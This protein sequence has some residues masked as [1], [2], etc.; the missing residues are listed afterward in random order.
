MF[1]APTSISCDIMH[2]VQT[3]KEIIYIP[4]PFKYSQFPNIFHCPIDSLKIR[5][6]CKYC[7][8]KSIEHGH[9]VLVPKDWNNDNHILIFGSIEPIQ[10]TETHF[11]THSHQN[12]HFYILTKTIWSIFFSYFVYMFNLSKATSWN[13]NELF[14]KFFYFQIQFYPSWL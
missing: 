10:K 11:W 8:H 5:S 1:T 3:K 13:Y 2:I 7:R 6:I 12:Q 14:L 4:K 9:S